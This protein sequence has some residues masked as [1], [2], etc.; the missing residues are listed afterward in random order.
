MRDIEALI[1]SSQARVTGDARVTLAPG[2]FQVTGVRSPHSLMR[3][4]AGLYGEQAR[5]WDGRD[6]EGFGRI[7]GIPGLLAHRA[8][9]P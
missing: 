1:E 9:A 7:L 3:K 5:L 2:R 6:A 8:G 4:E